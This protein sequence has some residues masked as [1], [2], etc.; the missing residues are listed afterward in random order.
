MLKIES[1]V[2]QSGVGVGWNLGAN[3]DSYAVEVRRVMFEDFELT[4]Y[5]SPQFMYR[6]CCCKALQYIQRETQVNI[7]NSP[8]KP[9]YHKYFSDPSHLVTASPILEVSYILG[10][11]HGVPA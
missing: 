6:H 9:S 5:P 8:S 3:Y 1:R 11:P 10:G 7:N 2:A 4:E